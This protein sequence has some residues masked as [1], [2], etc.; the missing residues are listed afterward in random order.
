MYR[1]CIELC[2]YFT[3]HRSCIFSAISNT[4]H[5]FVMPIMKML[6]VFYFAFLVI[7]FISI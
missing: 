2:E 7:I 6:C 5:C 3:Q 1:A 4:D